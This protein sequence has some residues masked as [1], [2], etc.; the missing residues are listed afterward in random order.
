[1]VD[2]AYLTGAGS[3]RRQLGSRGKASVGRSTDV[4]QPTSTVGSSTLV[5]EVLSTLLE[6]AMPW[7]CKDRED[8]F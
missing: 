1:M 3:P 5:S 8:D 2:L 4:G 7:L 6:K